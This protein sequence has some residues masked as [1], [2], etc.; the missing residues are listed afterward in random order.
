MTFTL[1]MTVVDPTPP[2]SIGGGLL[3]VLAAIFGFKAFKGLRIGRSRVLGL[4]A[5]G[6]EIDVSFIKTRTGALGATLVAG[7][8]GG[9]G[10]ITEI[11]YE[12]VCNALNN[13]GSLMA[14]EALGSVAVGNSG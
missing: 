5:R 10:L 12:A 13:L 11:L 8:G 1:R 4:S 14:R 7:G 9:G 6:G 3:S 2:P